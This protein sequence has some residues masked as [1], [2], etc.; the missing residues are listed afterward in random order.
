MDTKVCT[1]CRI[2]KPISEFHHFGKN[3]SRVGKWCEACYQKSAG[4]PGGA[5]LQPPKTS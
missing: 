5:P 4:G 2:E 1:S 3:D